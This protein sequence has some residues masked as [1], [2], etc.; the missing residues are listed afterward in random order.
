[1]RRRSSLR[2]AHRGLEHAVEH[3]APGHAAA[4][5]TPTPGLS[6]VCATSGHGHDG[7]GGGGARPPP[8]S[9]FARGTPRAPVR[10]PRG[11]RAGSGGGRPRVGQLL[12]QVRRQRAPRAL[13]VLAL[14]LL[15]D[16]DDEHLPGA[17]RRD[18]EEPELLGLVEDLLGFLQL[19]PAGRLGDLDDPE[20][21]GFA[22]HPPVAPRARA[23]AVDREPD[24][25]VALPARI[26]EEHDGRLEP[27]GAVNG[28]AGARRRAGPAARSSPRCSPRS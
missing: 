25:P 1:M 13:R 26:G 14:S 22:D 2:V 18:V 16:A 19:L 12:R 23:S 15:P 8:A 20:S 7:V 9:P 10:R 5:P 3:A 6:P 28:H 27:L 21:L 11:E 4:G 17:G 24:R